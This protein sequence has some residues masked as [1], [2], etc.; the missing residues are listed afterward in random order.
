MKDITDDDDDVGNELRSLCRR[1]S[2]E[3]ELDSKVRKQAEADSYK[4]E[5]FLGMAAS[6]FVCDR[7][8]G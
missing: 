3:Q 1:S 5:K 8:A 6:P 2:M 4:L 7:F